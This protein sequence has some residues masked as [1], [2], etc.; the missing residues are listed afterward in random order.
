VKSVSFV[1]INVFD[2]DK[3]LFSFTSAYKD[4]SISNTKSIVVY[5]AESRTMKNP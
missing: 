2:K 5:S 3:I 1:Q 4:S